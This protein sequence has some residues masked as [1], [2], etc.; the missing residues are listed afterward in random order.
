MIT[1]NKFNSIQIDIL[2]EKAKKNEDE[3]I[4]STPVNENFKSKIK[5]EVNS[6]NLYLC[7]NFTRNGTITEEEIIKDINDNKKFKEFKEKFV[8]SVIPKIKFRFGKNIVESELFSQF[9]ILKMLTKE[10]NLF[11]KDL[12]A[13]KINS[14]ILLNACMNILIF[15]R[16]SK[17]FKSKSEVVEMLNT[18]FF[19]YYEKYIEYQK[20]EEKEKEKEKQK[21]KERDKE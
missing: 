8:K 21:E 9:Q 10:Y 5:K 12:D 17:E 11:N 1:I 16:N 20:K 2:A 19:I 3:G 6:K 18:I 14:K 7:Y 4:F 13:S 15:I